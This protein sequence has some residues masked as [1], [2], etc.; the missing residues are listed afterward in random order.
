MSVQG[1][2]LWRRQSGGG[3]SELALEIAATDLGVLAAMLDSHNR[4]ESAPLRARLTLD[5]PGGLSELALA[6]A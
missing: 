6:H 4:I 5:W 2:A 3:H 1:S